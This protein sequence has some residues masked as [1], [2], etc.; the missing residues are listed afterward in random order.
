MAKA[1]RKAAAAPPKVEEEQQLA[2]GGKGRAVKAAPPAKVAEEEPPAKRGKG[3]AVPGKAGKG[4]AEG[5]VAAKKVETEA[6]KKPS[7]PRAAKGKVGKGSADGAVEA[8]KVEKKAVK[9]P[10]AP[11]AVNS[12][13][14]KGSAEWNVEHITAQSDWPITTGGYMQTPTFHPTEEEF[15][16]FHGYMNKLDRLVGH[17]GVCKVVPPPGWKPRKHDFYCLEDSFP[18]LDESVTVRSRTMLPRLN[19]PPHTIRWR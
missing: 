8:K 10:S 15:S 6:V 17:M 11:R 12:K 9:K 18:A 3:R 7:A 2:K 16:D 13:A 4:G 14:G 19:E 5:A 1:K